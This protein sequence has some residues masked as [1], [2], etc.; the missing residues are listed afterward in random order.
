[1]DTAQKEKTSKIR[2]IT[3]AYLIAMQ[4]IS[5][6]F[7][8]VMLVDKLELPFE[9]ILGVLV[10]SGL[11]SAIDILAMYDLVMGKTLAIGAFDPLKSMREEVKIKVCPGGNVLSC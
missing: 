3:L 10:I 1:M 6:Y 7:L 11:M 5:V 8:Y 4:F 2:M 9:K